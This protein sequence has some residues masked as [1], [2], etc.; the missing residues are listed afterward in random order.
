LEYNSLDCC[1]DIHILIIGPICWDEIIYPS[2]EREGH[3]GGSVFYTTQAI[4][5]IA[6]YLRYPVS[7]DVW[8]HVGKDRHHLAESLFNESNV[9]RY[10]TLQERTLQFTNEYVD[11]HDWTK[12][13]QTVTQPVAKPIGSPEAPEEITEKLRENQY[14]AIFLLPLT[15]YD[16]MDLTADMVPYLK[17]YDS[18]SNIA[19]ELQGFMR[20]F[21]ADGG[22][23]T[24]RVSEALP[25]LF[26]QQ[27]VGC[28]HC[29]VEEGIDLVQAFNNY[30]NAQQL[31]LETIATQICRYGVRSVGLTNGDQ[32]AFVA[33]QNIRGAYVSQHIPTVGLSQLAIQPYVTG[34]GDTW[35]GIYGY[36]LLGLGFPPVLAASLATQFATL[37]CL[38]DGALGD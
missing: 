36:A 14:R 22:I 25:L 21:P 23:V 24:S 10:Y 18:E 4:L 37:K 1:K 29:S 32:G 7:I 33:W 17:R 9:T 13:E 3:I 28:M 15:P 26:K 30:D 31:P 27:T 6:K 8:A 20:D 16:F 35:F 38:R 5:Y 12:R 11:E 19:I 34:A 2:G